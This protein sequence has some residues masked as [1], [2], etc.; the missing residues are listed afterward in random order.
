MFMVNKKYFTLDWTVHVYS[1]KI[2]IAEIFGRGDTKEYVYFCILTS[3]SVIKFVI[4]RNIFG[5]LSDM[6]VSHRNS[7]F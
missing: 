2:T 1:V 4:L 5:K 3:P 6:R 7:P